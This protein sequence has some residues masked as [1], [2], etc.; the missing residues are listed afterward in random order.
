MFVPKKSLVFFSN[1]PKCGNALHSFHC[2]EF[3]KQQ[4]LLSLNLHKIK[5]RKKKNKNI[6][7]YL[8]KRKHT[9]VTPAEFFASCSF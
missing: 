6:Y 3:N 2:N 7:P 1:F 9:K 4:N 5:T 8:W